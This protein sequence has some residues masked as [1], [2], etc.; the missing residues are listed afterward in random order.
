MKIITA[1]TALVLTAVTAN[2]EAW[3]VSEETS[4][5][6]DSKTVRMLASSNESITNRFGR[7][8]DHI[9]LKIRCKENTTAMYF[10]FEGHHM[11]DIQGYGQ[12]KMRVDDGQAFTRG[13]SVSTDNTA[14]GLWRG[15][16]IGTIKRFFGGDKLVMQATP[17]GESKIT[18][19][20]DLTDIKD[21]I[22]PLRQACHW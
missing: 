7:G 3:F 17:Y 15:N 2:A 11:A 19:T 13:M 5:M 21:E 22:K 6:D 10:Q 12:V 20:F 18:T 9:N 4:P 16:G 14:L 1:T 8:S